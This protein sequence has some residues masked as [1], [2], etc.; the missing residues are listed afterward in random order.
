[1]SQS[2]RHGLNLEKAS[3]R[4]F[5]DYVLK[6][7]PTNVLERVGPGKVIYCGKGSN[8]RLDSAEEPFKDN[9][10]WSGWE[11]FRRLTPNEKTN[12]QEQE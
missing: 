9:M 4:L 2:D 3:D 1:M 7:P 6:C 10:G 11:K 12:L 8:R 5:V